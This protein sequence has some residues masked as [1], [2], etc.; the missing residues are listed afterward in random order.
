MSLFSITDSGRLQLGAEMSHVA[1]NIR[2]VIKS[3]LAR[4][5]LEEFNCLSLKECPL[6]SL[7][8]STKPQYSNLLTIVY[9]LFGTGKI[10]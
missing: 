2:N 4:I 6:L 8:G 1:D 9:T 10:T 5:L 7:K 3:I